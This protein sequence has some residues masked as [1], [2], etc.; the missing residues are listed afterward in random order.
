M[1]KFKFFLSKFAEPITENHPVWNIPLP[2]SR[3][4]G[5][6]SDKRAFTCGDYFKAAEA[7]LSENHF[8]RLV[9]SVCQQSNVLILPETIENISVFLEKHG[10]FYHPSKIEVSTGSQQ[11]D[12]VLNVAVSK[13]GLNCL[14]NEFELLKKLRHELPW[15]FIPAVYEKSDMKPAA[16][17]F[18]SQMFSGEWFTGFNEFHIH[19][20]DPDGNC[21]IEVWDQARGN[22][23]ISEKQAYE[24]YSQTALI[25]TCYFNL[26]T[27][28]QIHPWH[29][30]AGDFVL[31]ISGD[32]MW[33][34]LVTI[35]GYHPLICNDTIDMESIM[36]AMVFFLMD[37]SIQNRI[38]R[39]K[40]VGDIAWADDIYV[41]ASIDGFFKGLDQKIQSNII[42]QRLADNL[43]V[44]LKSLTQS[45]MENFFTEIILAWPRQAPELPMIK[46]KIRSHAIVFE[47]FTSQFLSKYFEKNR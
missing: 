30:A 39:F 47:Y 16:G 37:L 19:S 2:V 36:E 5:A 17:E 45:D 10:E 28:E 1:K 12:F 9:S 35:R 8:Q 29:H 43:G 33:V 31:K 6:N 38:D 11:Y 18:A 41:M 42:S 32:R 13:T 46:D 27:F 44:Y 22:H 24:L 23:F 4:H 14:K 21:R 34:K 40:G 26:K 7:F 3:H 25:L 20:F 15:E